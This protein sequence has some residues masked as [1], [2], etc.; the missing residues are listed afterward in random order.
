MKHYYFLI[1][2]IGLN[3]SLCQF[4]NGQWWL[5]PL[6]SLPLKSD[7]VPASFRFEE[8]EKLIL[9]K[10]VGLVINHTSQ[11]KGTALVDTLQKRGINI[12]KI[13]APEHGFRG[14]AEAG[15]IIHGEIDIKTGIKIVSLY[16]KHKKPDKS[17]LRNLDVLLFDIQDVGV[18][19]YTYIST[20]KLVMEACA[21]NGKQLLVCD[22]ANPLGFCVDG[23]I[24]EPGFESFVGA[25]Q[26]PVVHGLTVGELAQMAKQ[27]RWF[28]KSRKLKLQTIKCLGYT[29]NDT[30]FPELPPSPNLPNPLSI[31]AYPSLCLFEGTNISVGRGTDFPFQVFA[32][33]DSLFGP[34]QFT[35][36]HKIKEGPKPIHCNRT[37][38]GYALT[39]DSI[40][41]C[42]DIRFLRQ[43]YNK[44]G[45]DKL[46]F[47]T[48]FDTL[49]GSKKLKSII[50]SGEAFNPDLSNYLAERKKFLLY[51]EY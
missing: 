11:Y 1:F 30:I 7:Y 36:R 51:P 19:F 37:C 29:H 24:L 46:F 21:E 31:L 18:R 17:E 33:V 22:R 42:F 6:T 25:F 26:I 15:Q 50:K 28:K 41:K 48:F 9:G 14:T 35:P 49:A 23:P 10:R 5:Q 27:K 40:K 38:F 44:S 43:A 32:S 12:V 3:L 16:G 45:K 39:L 4:A 20:L 2:Q 8:Y 47:N 13:F 34:F